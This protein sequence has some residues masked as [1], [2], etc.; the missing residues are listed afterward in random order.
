M[1]PLQQDIHQHRIAVVRALHCKGLQ[2]FLV[3]LAVLHPGQT[4]LP[5][6]PLPHRLFGA[7]LGILGHLC[8]Q[9]PEQ[10]GDVQQDAQL[11]NGTVPGDLQGPVQHQGRYPSQAQQTKGHQ[12]EPAFVGVVPAVVQQQ[13]PHQHQDAEGQQDVGAKQHLDKGH[14]PHQVHSPLHQGVEVEQPCQHPG[15]PPQRGGHGVLDKVDHGHRHEHKGVKGHDTPG[16]RCPAIALDHAGIGDAPQAAKEQKQG[17]IQKPG[18]P[19][20][21]LADVQVAGQCQQTNGQHPHHH[22]NGH[23]GVLQVVACNGVKSPHR[24][25]QK[26][27]G[28]LPGCRINNAEGGGARFLRQQHICPHLGLHLVIFGEG[29]VGVAV[30]QGL[31]QPD[32]QIVLDTAYGKQLSGILCRQGIVDQHH[33]AAAV[34]GLFQLGRQGQGCGILPLQL[35]PALAQGPQV[36]PVVLFRLCRPDPGQQHPQ[37]QQQHRHPGLFQP[38]NH[39]LAIDFH[40][41]LPLVPLARGIQVIC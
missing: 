12:T 8:Q 22:Q 28:P 15:G 33:L 20:L 39:P 18:F 27:M 13:D 37:Q 29:V 4:V 17:D 1:Q 30:Q 24:R 2:I 14:P 21:V 7:E 26:G 41:V 25:G 16:C 11:E 35:I 40:S 10:Q 32:L 34:P 6:K 38:G 9:P 31:A 5:G 3:G 36:C 23:Q 19:D